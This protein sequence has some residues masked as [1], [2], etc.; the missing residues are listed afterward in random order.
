MRPSLASPKRLYPE[1]PWEVPW[2]QKQTPLLLMGP[3]LTWS[4][5]EVLTLSMG[6]V[7]MLSLGVEHA[8]ASGMPCPGSAWHS[9]L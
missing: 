2:R 3:E 5:G 9:G 6:G 8:K 7:N 4:V 1:C